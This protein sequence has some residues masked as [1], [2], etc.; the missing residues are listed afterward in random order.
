MTIIKVKNLALTYYNHGY[1][2]HGMHDN[3]GNI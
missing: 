2:G 3:T 1:I